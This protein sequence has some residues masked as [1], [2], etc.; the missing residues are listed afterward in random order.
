MQGGKRTVVLKI[1]AKHPDKKLIKRAA[2]ILRSGGLVGFPTETV[3]G[4]GANLLNEAAIAK[5]YKVKEIK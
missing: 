3:Y 1:D 2:K 5:L 4:I